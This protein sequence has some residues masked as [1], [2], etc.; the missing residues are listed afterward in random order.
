MRVF[1]VLVALSLSTLFA[2]S[3][4][5]TITG[6]ASDA[7]S[8]PIPGA[9]VIVSSQDTG[10]K[11]TAPTNASGVYSVPNLKPGKYKVAASAQGFRPVETPVIDLTAFQTV[12][13]D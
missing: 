12:R 1:S 10:V 2:Q 8:A 7:T 5:G 13:Q 11:V 3:P 4:L 9:S 6:I